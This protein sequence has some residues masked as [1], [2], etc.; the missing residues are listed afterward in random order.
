MKALGLWL[1]VISGIG[2]HKMD[3]QAAF[4]A[5]TAIFLVCLTIGCGLFTYGGKS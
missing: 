1:I 5:R 4:D 3:W 2:L